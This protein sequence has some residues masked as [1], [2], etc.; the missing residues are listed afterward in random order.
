MTGPASAVTGAAWVNGPRLPGPIATAREVWHYRRF[1]RYLGYRAMR[2]LYARTALGWIWIV[3][4]P[5][6]PILVRVLVFGGLL[7]LTSEG[8]PYFLFLTVGTVSWNLFASGLMWSTR[9]LELNRRVV[10]QVYVPKAILPIATTAP[11]VFDFL[12]NMAVLVLAVVFYRVKDG[13]TYLSLGLHTLWSLAAIVLTMLLVLGIG[14]FTSVWGE[15]ARDARFT[16]GHLL[17]IGFLVTPVLY[18]V[19]SVPAAYRSW[20]YANPMA[21]FVQA[22]KYGLLGRERPDPLHFAIAAAVTLTVLVSGLFFFASRE[23]AE[24]EA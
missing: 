24:A 8:V 11:A 5:L 1:L 22:F 2:K 4:R 16:A 14:F 10:T 9:G 7:G 3:I 12:V 6:F 21:A 17:T 18:S 15:R 23:E 20:L 19:S 13:T